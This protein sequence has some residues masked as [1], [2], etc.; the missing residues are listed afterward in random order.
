[1]KNI[2]ERREFLEGTNGENIQ[3]NIIEGKNELGE[4]RAVAL[5]KIDTGTHDFKVRMDVTKETQELVML[6]LSKVAEH[7]TLL[8]QEVV[9]IKFEGDQ[10]PQDVKLD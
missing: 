9:K 1:M 3:S 4:K 6:F 5:L 10:P 7:A 2:Y 8:R